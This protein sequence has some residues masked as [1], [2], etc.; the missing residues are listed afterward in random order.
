M[1][2]VNE[3]TIASNLRDMLGAIIPAN[4]GRKHLSRIVP[5]LL[6]EEMTIAGA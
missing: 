1:G 3:C 6:V 4:D 5:S 2:P